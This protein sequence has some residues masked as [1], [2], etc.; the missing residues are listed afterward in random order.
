MSL[1]GPRSISEGLIR[2]KTPNRVPIDSRQIIR[3][4]VKFPSRVSC[5]FPIELCR[6]RRCRRRKTPARRRTPDGSGGGSE[7]FL[8]LRPPFYA[9][10]VAMFFFPFASFL[11]SLLLRDCSGDARAVDGSNPNSRCEFRLL[12]IPSPCFHLQFKICS[13]PSIAGS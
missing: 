5:D 9:L 2:P 3:C 1:N 11:T 4:Q 13:A 6:S 12:V 8:Q 7:R 10:R